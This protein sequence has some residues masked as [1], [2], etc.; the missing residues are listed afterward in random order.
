MRRKNHALL[1]E[2]SSCSMAN[3]K[4][5]SFPRSWR[6]SAEGGATVD[7]KGASWSTLVGELGEFED[8]T[9][10]DVDDDDEEEE[11]M[12]LGRSLVDDAIVVEVW[13]LPIIKGGRVG[14]LFNLLLFMAA[15]VGLAPL[16]LH[17]LGDTVL[18][19]MV[20]TLG[21]DSPS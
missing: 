7:D 4:R 1:V 10:E 20:P 5:S 11:D 21:A 16:L 13:G 9:D 17:K 2:E 8:W 15:D 12:S 19:L 18:V 14:M 6:C 3:A